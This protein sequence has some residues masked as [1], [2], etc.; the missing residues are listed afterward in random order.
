MLWA[1]EL[2][3]LKQQS[4]RAGKS[5]AIFSAYGTVKLRQAGRDD[6]EARFAVEQILL[7]DDGYDVG[8][9]LPWGKFCW[10]YGEMFGM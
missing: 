10:S 7:E 6:D 4:P 5:T 9:A 2:T 1:L 8:L 3:A